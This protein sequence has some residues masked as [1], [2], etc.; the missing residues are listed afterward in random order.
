MALDKPAG[1]Q[2]LFSSIV[3]QAAA[4]L[5]LCGSSGLLSQQSGAFGGGELC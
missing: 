2:S 3:Q 5:I 4:Q 1:V